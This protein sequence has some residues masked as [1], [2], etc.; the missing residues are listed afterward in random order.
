[1]YRLLEQVNPNLNN[2]AEI[3]MEPKYTTADD[4]FTFCKKYS[5]YVG[6]QRGIGNNIYDMLAYN[7]VH[8]ILS[9]ATN[10]YTDGLSECKKLYRDYM[11]SYDLWNVGAK[12][13]PAPVFPRHLKLDEL[14]LS[15]S[16]YSP[17]NDKGRVNTIRDDNIPYDWHGPSP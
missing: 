9:R 11:H 4:V 17:D 3:I 2:E 13:S 5:H 10:H 8:Q 15:I 7:Y 12:T 6:Y 16:K 1:M 14:P